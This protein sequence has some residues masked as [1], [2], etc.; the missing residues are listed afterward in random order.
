[1]TWSA[2]AQP[3]PPLPTPREGVPAAGGAARGEARSAPLT[4]LSI[5]PAQ[6]EPGITVT[7]NGNG[8]TDRTVAFLGATEVRTT[9]VADKVLTLVIPD[10]Q[11]GLYALYLRREDGTTSRPYNFSVQP[12]RPEISSLSPEKIDACAAGR[13]REVTVNGLNF[14][15]GAQIVFDGGGIG[16]R[17]VSPE[18]VAFV[19]P[20]L[21]SGLH[22][23]MVRNPSGA[24]SDPLALIIDSKPEISNVAIGS[25]Y[26]SY[27]ELIVSGRNFQQGSTLV[28]DGVRIH[29]GEPRAGNRE[30]LIYAGC[31]QIIYQ[32]HPYDATPKDLRLQVVNP[33]GEESGVVSVTAP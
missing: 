11:P 6:G 8:F 27:Y 2:V 15:R 28:V 29:T 26:V 22:Q 33:N 1:M 16:T 14:Q 9:L 4:V 12:V 25:D 17:F 13:E 32:R 18:A 5:I 23:V 3:L 21:P 24:A 20:Q 30:S 7:L 10:L 19:T 31:S